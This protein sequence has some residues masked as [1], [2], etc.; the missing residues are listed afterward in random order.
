MMILSVIIPVYNEAQSIA[1]TLTALAGNRNIS[2]MEII[3]VDG[4]SND[5]T[6][7]I[8]KEL[9][10]CT[11]LQS[12][13]KGRAA[14]MNFGVR[15][16]KGTVL[17]FVHGDVN[18]HPDY[19]THINH[20]IMEGVDFGCYR[21]RFHSTK[22]LLKFN[23]Y[24]TRFNSI[25][26]G[27]GDQTLLIRKDVFEQLHGFRDDFVIMEDF[28]LINRAKKKGF[29]FRILPFSILVSARKYDKN[30]WLRVQVANTIIM[31]A[32]KF[33]AGQQWMKNTYRKML[34]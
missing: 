12:P 14:Q 17:Y 22:K 34:H 21:Y 11:V 9:G 7:A 1:T 33:G 28:D 26:A 23:G 5:Q 30:S 24:M 31:L 27:G 2:E 3:V 13:V 18:V 16:A 20:A 19:F 8:A 25:W 4:G 15:K 29:I 32:W 10:C 6:I